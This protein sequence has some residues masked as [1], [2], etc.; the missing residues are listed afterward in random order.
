MYDALWPLSTLLLHEV[1]CESLVH[2][3]PITSV[4]GVCSKVAVYVVYAWPGMASLFVGNW[5]PVWTGDVGVAA[6]AR[7]ADVLIGASVS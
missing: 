4:H 5:S 1:C 7:Q 2:V 6:L 3:Y